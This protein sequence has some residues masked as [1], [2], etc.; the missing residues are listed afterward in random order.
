[1]RRQ[2]QRAATLTLAVIA[3]VLGTGRASLVAQ[4]PPASAPPTVT[5][6]VLGSSH[7]SPVVENLDLFEDYEVVQDLDALSPVEKG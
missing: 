7:F 3:I 6:D 2:A 4:A 5:G 1:M